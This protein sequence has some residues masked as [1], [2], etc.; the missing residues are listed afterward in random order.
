[1][2][3]RTEVIGL[4]PSCALARP[5]AGR[6]REESK[7]DFR[8]IQTRSSSNPSLQLIS[9]VRESQISA[10]A[11][12]KSINVYPI[13][14]VGSHY[15]ADFIIGNHSWIQRCMIDPGANINC[16][17]YDWIIL[18]E[19]PE[20]N[21]NLECGPVQT[22]GG[23]QLEVEACVLLTIS[24]PPQHPVLS[25]NQSFYIVHDEDGVVLGT[26]ACRA[27]GVIDKQWP[28]STLQERAQLDSSAIKT[29]HA[30]TV[31][32]PAECS[33]H[34]YFPSE[35]HSPQHPLSEDELLSNLNWI[36]HSGNKD[37]SKSMFFM[38]IKM[39]LMRL[40]S[41]NAK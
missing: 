11:S 2:F 39:F 32:T 1:M 20:W 4:T 23:Y 38:N 3:V 8:P 36:H 33:L 19:T 15:Q 18:F 34:D 13:P 10:T 21:Y 27:L 26:P 35:I 22:A 40:F 9:A 14:S 31:H 30:D 41:C 17:G 5:S 6:S 28:L 16:A 37:C 12:V 7:P 25:A 24:W 29:A